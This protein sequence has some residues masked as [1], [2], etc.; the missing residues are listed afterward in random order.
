TI[1]ISSDANLGDTSGSLTIDGGTLTSAAAI[2]IA[3]SRNVSL[4]AAGATFD[5]SNTSTFAGI[6]GG[7]GSLTKSGAGNLILVSGNTFGGAGQTV[8]VKA[9]SLSIS[10]DSSLGNPA[11]T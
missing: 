7:A 4:G 3:A 2:S 10:F 6:I 5:F 9:G 8:T 11:N 1:S